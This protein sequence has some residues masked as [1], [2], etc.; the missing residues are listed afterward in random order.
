MILLLILSLTC[1]PG[2]QG[3]AVPTGSGLSSDTLIP[4]T[5]SICQLQKAKKDFDMSKVCIKNSFDA[6]HEWLKHVENQL[7][8]IFQSSV[9]RKMVRS[10]IRLW[11][12]KKDE[13]LWLHRFWLFYEWWWWIK[14]QFYI[15]ISCQNWV[16]LP[17][18]VIF[19]S[20]LNYSC[21]MGYKTPRR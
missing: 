8:H 13:S 14:V 5:Q 7:N 4:T 2:G 12:T 15:Q 19:S 9:F 21:N 16:L 3:V 1:T 18:S 10:W 17:R 11:K 20:K 6:V